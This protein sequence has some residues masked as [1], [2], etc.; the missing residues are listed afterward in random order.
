MIGGVHRM[1][2]TG[3]WTDEGDEPRLRVFAHCIISRDITARL[4]NNP[5]APTEPF[6]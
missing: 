2:L 1:P 3:Q 6:G 5:R 4:P